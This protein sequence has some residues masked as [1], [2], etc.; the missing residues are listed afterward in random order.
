MSQDL[1]YY[2]Y[3]S[4]SKVIQLSEQLRDFTVEKKSVKRS[5]SAEVKGEASGMLGFFKAALSGGGSHRTEVEETGSQTT[6][7]KLATVL[8]YIENNTKVLD[9]GQLCRE[10]AGV[11][12]DA[13][14]YVYEGSFYS[15]GTFHR[16]DSGLQ[17]T[18]AALR[19]SPDDIVLSK[20]LLLAPASSENALK[21]VGPNQSSLVSDMTIICSEIGIYTLRLACSYKYFSDMGGSWDEHDNEW[22]VHPHSGNYHFFEGDTDAYFRAVLFLNGI[23][24]NTIMGTPL[25]I[26]YA[27]N[28]SLRI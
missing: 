23:R 10:R 4:R 16:G 14:C 12:L 24:G 2:S 9:L 18:A 15:L 1:T 20:S 27:T 5:N 26:A 7:Q 13:F 19:K 17:I 28:P 3:I 22:T 6:V 21:E 8:E 11:T 25:C